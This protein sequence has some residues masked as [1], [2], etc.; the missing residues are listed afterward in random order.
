LL[1][2]REEESSGRMQLGKRSSDFGSEFGSLRAGL[3]LYTRFF[4]EMKT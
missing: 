1:T 3:P 2:V 4:R